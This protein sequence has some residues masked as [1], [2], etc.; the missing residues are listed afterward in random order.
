MKITT[1]ARTE[2][3]ALIKWKNTLSSSSSLN[4]W[5][6]TNLKNH[7][8]WAG[9]VCNNGGS[10]TEI[11]IRNFTLNG[12]LDQFNFTSLPNLNRFD[13]NFNNLNG[14]IPSRIA[15]LSNLTFI[16][17]GGNYFTENI[18][19]EIGMLSELRVLNLS[20]NN[21]VGEIP[22]QLSN[23]QKAWY[24]DLGQN[25][26]ES[27]D[28]SKFS[29]MP[30]LTHLS[31]STNELTSEFPPF[32]LSCR[33]LT[34]LDL[35]VNNLTGS[36]PGTLVTNLGKIEY[37]NLTGNFFHGPLPVNLSKLSKLKHLFL[38]NNEFT[39]AIPTEIG[40][41]SDLQILELY[42][43]SFRGKI[44]SSLGQ[45]RMLE[46][47][48][49][50]N[51]GLNSTIPSKL[52]R[53]ANLTFID[54]SM[55][56]LSGALPLSLSSLTKISA[57]VILDNLLS[58]A[59]SPYLITNWTELIY[60]QLQNIFTRFHLI[61]ITKL[62]I[63]YLYKKSALWFD[64]SGDWE[65]EYLVKLA[66]QR[67]VSQLSGSIPPEIGNLN[68][69]VKLVLLEN[70]FTGPIPPTL[71]N[72][73]KLEILY[74]HTN[75]LSGSI[76]PEIGNLNDLVDLELS[77]NSFTGPI[78][79]EI[80]NLRSMTI[81]DINTN[82]FEGDLPDTI[83]RLD[84]LEVLSLFKNNF[85]GTIPKDLGSNSSSLNSV[86]FS[87]NRFSGELPP[88]LCNGFALENFT[89]DGNNL[90]GPLPDCLKN[91]TG[92]KRVRLEGN[93]FTGDVSKAFGVHPKLYYID[94]S[95][96]LFSGKLSPAWGEWESL[97]LLHVDGNKISGEIPVEFGK[98]TKLQDLSLSSNELRGSIPTELGDLDL[99]FKLNLSNNHLTGEIPQG[100]GNL[101]QL[102]F[103]DLSE[104]TLTG[105]IPKEL[106]KL[107]S[108]ENMSLSNN[109]LSGEIPSELGNLVALQIF[110]DLSSN[111][112]SGTIPPNLG[113]LT[114]L[115]NLNLSHNN[116]SGRIPT[117]LSSRISLESI[118]LSYNE[119]TG[120]VPTGNIFQKT[121]AED[122]AGNSGL[123]GNAGLPSCNS[124]PTGA[125]KSKHCN[126]EMEIT[127]RD[128]ITKPLIWEREG[129]F[130]FGDIAK[131]TEDFNEI[132]CIG[133][134]GFGSV[135]K[136]V[137]PTG[138]IVAVK[139]LHLSDSSDIP[140]I[141]RRSFENEIEYVERGSL[142]K[143]LYGEEGGSELNWVTRVN[144]I[145]GVAHATAYLHHD[146]SPPIVHRDISAN[147]ILLETG[148][149]PRLSDFGTARLLSSDSSNWTMVAGSYGYMAPELAYTMRVTE[150]CDVYSFGVV[151][152]E[153]MMGRHPGELI[154][155]LSS[156]SSGDR[157]L[158]L[159]DVLDQRLP[160]PTGQLAKE[161]VCVVTMALACTHTNPESRPTMRSVAQELSASTQVYLSESFLT[162]TIT[163]YQAFKNR[164]NLE[165]YVKRFQITILLTVYI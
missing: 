136:A 3:E 51:I 2:A 29:S 13:L 123:C 7:C 126:E 135:Y 145:Q 67:T 133:K 124:S 91:C 63:L 28:W 131:A 99:L 61:G 148:F 69:L 19:S 86:Y 18:P 79:P 85:S 108:L 41:I 155:S 110:L 6:L 46:R 147:N 74:L 109:D 49:L 48:D 130:T 92:L 87:I 55:N 53:C 119:L 72:L 116:L 156:W 107:T 9:I 100:L 143:V 23:L 36:L 89:A 142:R 154:S 161:I 54:F 103:L 102:Q 115:E 105:N 57:F 152:L 52:G 149:E 21:L 30:L 12:T 137:L 77:E 47:L 68:H 84:N 97:T 150:K 120:P 25:S 8:N 22:Y 118:D 112:F 40:L 139:R 158:L 75:Q 64:P 32:I 71:G 121:T 128:V 160:P 5:S 96:N 20:E 59:I 88:G 39:G 11:N 70:S 144:I 16:D 58:G 42:N 98:L 44:P 1:S 76:P 127:A 101:S 134:G 26:L 80:G 163:S 95:H 138:Q 4:S 56:S 33:N 65:P 90:T 117:T 106:G 35:S 38:G 24:F 60:L 157:D 83:S 37:L 162:I 81:L 82:K 15:N 114:K 73:T 164:T 43:N 165:K 140:A 153:V 10:I 78:P 132:Y 146:C 17:L 93:R 141:N 111:S 62:E 129:K 122:F 125:K 151:A 45:L 14:S 94:L 159:K 34:F 66:S 50:H 27:T 113:K 104:N 31:L